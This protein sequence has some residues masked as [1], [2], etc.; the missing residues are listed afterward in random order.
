LRNFLIAAHDAI[1]TA[2]ALLVSFILRFE[3]GWFRRAPAAVAAY[4]A[5]VCRVPAVVVCY[6]FQA[7]HDKMAVSFRLPD[8]LKHSC[9]WSSVLTLALLVLDYIF[10]TPDF[11]GTFLSRP[12]CHRS[13]L[14][15]PGIFSGAHCDS[16]TVISGTPGRGHP[17][18]D[19]QRFV[20]AFD[21]PRRRMP[22]IV[23]RGIENG[24]IKRLWPVGRAVAFEPRP[25]AS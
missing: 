23:L 12:D 8:A 7:D 18:P 4:P 3:G 22:R 24:A 17:R 11:H 1:A 25:R 19:R 14:V 5:L 20:D 16:A 2:L 9:A 13:L 10:V 15:S 21:R 6:A